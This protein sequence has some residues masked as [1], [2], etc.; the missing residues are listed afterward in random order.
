M[1]EET[2]MTKMTK[3]TKNF[4]ALM[5]KMTKEQREEIDTRVQNELTKMKKAELNYFQREDILHLTL[6]EEAETKSI[7]INPHVTAEMNINGELI[8][9]EI[10]S[11]S[12]FLLNSLWDSIQAKLNDAD[13][14]D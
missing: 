13:C 1:K 11:A 9:I 10:S 7:E 14:E 2:K 5:G 3:M 6:S 12:S 8:G 4:E